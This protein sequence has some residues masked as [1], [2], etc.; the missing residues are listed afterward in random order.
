VSQLARLPCEVPLLSSGRR[1]GSCDDGVCQRAFPLSEAFH[2][3]LVAF[4][5]SEAR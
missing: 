4:P 5:L 3:T 1:G 2:A